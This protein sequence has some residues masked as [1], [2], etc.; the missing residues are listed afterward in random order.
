[1]T[2]KEL[3]IF[4]KAYQKRKVDDLKEAITVAYLN[5]QWTIAWLGKKH[6]QPRPLKEILATIGKEKKVMTDEQMLERVKQ[7]NALLG[8]EV[9]VIGS[10]KKLN[11]KIRR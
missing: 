6:Q 2:P 10:S 5:S 4:A 9:K 3:N 11:G 1:M 7:L 8:G